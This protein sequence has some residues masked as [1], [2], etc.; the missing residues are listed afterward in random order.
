[1]LE[2]QEIK[3]MLPHRYPFLMIDRVLEVVPQSSCKA[4]KNVTGN[5]PFFEGHFPGNPIMP[6][7]LIVEAIAQ[8]A[9]IVICYQSDNLHNTKMVLFGGIEKA[10]F[11]KPVIPGDQLLL[12][13]ELLHQRSQLWIFKGTAKV[14]GKI[15]V[16]AEVKLM[17]I[18][19]EV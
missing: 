4:L 16:Q 13:V 15:V 1:M 2:F 18:S 8:T 5:E 10:R 14:D 7:V 9:G 11:K 3:K 6:G 19:T 12:E 17:G